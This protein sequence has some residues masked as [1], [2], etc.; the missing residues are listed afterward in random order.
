MSNYYIYVV[1]TAS[2]EGYGLNAKWDYQAQIMVITVMVIYYLFCVWQCARGISLFNP[3]NIPQ[4][5][6][7]NLYYNNLRVNE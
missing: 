1:L 3:S 5:D 4:V 2:V 6:I 7:Y